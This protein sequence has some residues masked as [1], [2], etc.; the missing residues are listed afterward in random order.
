MNRIITVT[1]KRP[2]DKL[3]T[4]AIHPLVENTKI[5]FNTATAYACFPPMKKRTYMTA[6]FESPNLTP[7]IAIGN[8]GNE[9]SMID[10]MIAIAK[11][12]EVNTSLCVLPI[13]LPHHSESYYTYFEEQFSI[14]THLADKLHFAPQ[15]E[16]FLNEHIFD[17]G[18]R[19]FQKQ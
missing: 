9:F 14:L 11:N 3:K 8:G 19:I 6:M 2:P 5:A 17:P 12:K 16:A 7:G 4:L 18:N 10:N 1:D 13:I 15:Y